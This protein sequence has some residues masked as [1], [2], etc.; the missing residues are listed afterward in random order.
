MAL[1]VEGTGRCEKIDLETWSNFSLEKNRARMPH[2]R[3]LG[4]RHTFRF[5]RNFSQIDFFTSSRRSNHHPNPLRGLSTNGG[6]F[7]PEPYRDRSKHHPEG[8]GGQT[9]FRGQDGTGT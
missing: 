6:Y 2:K 8:F 3:P 7:V 1:G 4:L 9:K 5:G